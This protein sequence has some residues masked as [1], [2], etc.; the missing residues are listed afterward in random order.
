[1]AQSVL[2]LLFTPWLPS[3]ITQLPLQVLTC[4]EPRRLD[5]LGPRGVLRLHVPGELFRRARRGVD[6]LLEEEILDVRGCESGRQL[7]VEPVDE[8][9][10]RARRDEKTVPVIDFVAL[11][12]RFG[13]RRQ[14]G[15]ER[16][17]FRRGYRERPDF[18]GLDVRDRARR[19]GEAQ[20]DV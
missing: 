13:D 8:R 2:S 1:M 20:L 6:A 18:A 4:L 9:A 7:P 10:R 15:R 11:E 5:D 17:A 16:R 12:P 3:R 19:R 14:V